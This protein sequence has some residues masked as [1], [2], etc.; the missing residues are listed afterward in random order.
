MAERTIVGVDFSGAQTSNSTQVTKGV[1]RGSDLE[2]EPC[3]AL[4]KNLPCTHN[5]LKKLILDLRSDS[6]VALDFPFSVPWAFA[7]ALT[8]AQKKD[9]AFQMPDLW[10]IVAEAEMD[11]SRFE[12]LRNS[13]VERHGEVMR[14]GDANFAGPYSP[15]H[16]VNPSML[17][18]TYHGMRILHQFRKAGCRIPPLPDIKCK[19]PILLETMPG[20]LL[21][22][23][24]LPAVNYKTKNKSNDRDPEAVRRKILDGLESKSG[25]KLKNFDAIKSECIKNHD[26]LDSLVAAIGAAMWVINE[27]QFLTPRK[28]IPQ[29]EELDYALLEGWIYA[30]KK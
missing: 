21:R 28:S 5:K 4:P 2:L 22:T 3:D 13:F 8:D 30:P 15:L 25:V 6:V 23:F 1:L 29:T 27:S 17:K 19:G 20:V 9:R 26:K 10:G 12:K 16:V 11:Y 7:D 14:R 24:G 18:M